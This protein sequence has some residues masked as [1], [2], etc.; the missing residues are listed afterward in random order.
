MAEKKEKGAKRMAA[1]PSSKKK[2]NPERKG[3]GKTD[4][5]AFLK[6]AGIKESKAEEMKSLVPPKP[7]TPEEMDS[8]KKDVFKK[9][10]SFKKQLLRKHKDLV[11]TIF[12]FGSYLRNDFTKE[13]DLDILILLDDTKV[14]ITPEFK[15]RVTREAFDIAKKTDERLHVQ[16]AWTVTEFWEMVRLSHPLLHTVLRDGWALYDEGF[17]IPIKKLLE[18]GKIPATLEAVE[19]LMASAPQKIDRAKGVKL[20]QVTE[21]CYGAMLNSSQAILMYLGKPVPDPKNTPKA[22]KEYLVDTKILPKSYFEMLESVIKFRK[23]VEHKHIKDITGA[24]VDRW[25]KKAENYVKEMEKIYLN[26]QN[27]KKQ[28]VID[29]NYEVLIKST[30]FALKKMDKLPQ[31]PKDLPGAIKTHLVNKNYLPKSYLDTFNRV[32]GMKK[33]AEEDLSKIT[34]RDVELTRSYVKKFVDILDR[35]MNECECPPAEPVAKSSK[36]KRK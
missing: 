20:Y 7:L 10:E 26:L 22:I 18:R 14:M 36:K 21:D 31:D 1:G 3:K 6:E 16:P 9:A 25:I 4:E 29:R 17:F 2:E 30:I 8:I 27:Q 33:A 5:K 23:D 11:K 34:E 32:V 24:E 35:I 13:S 19:L 28:G 12:M 15:D